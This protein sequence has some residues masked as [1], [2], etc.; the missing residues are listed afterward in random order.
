MHGHGDYEK[1]RLIYDTLIGHDYLP[2]TENNSNKDLKLKEVK[3]CKGLYNKYVGGR[4]RGRRVS[5][6][7]MKY[8][9]HIVMGH[10]ICLKIF[11]GPQKISYVFLS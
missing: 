3:E 1:I 10:E 2:L 5:V 8:F 4:G 9:R 11:D 6:W 7:P